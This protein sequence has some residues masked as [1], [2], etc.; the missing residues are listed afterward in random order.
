MKMTS[1]IQQVN[2]VSQGLLNNNTEQ[3]LSFEFNGKSMTGYA[4]DTLASAL[5]ANGEKL[6][7][8]SF[9]YHRPRGIFSAG[10]EEPNALVELRK[11]AYQEPNTRA[12]IIELFDGLEAKSQNYRGSLKYDLM[13]INDRL[14][15][16]LSA[17]FYYKTFMW[18]KAFWEKLYEPIIRSSAGLGRLSA[19]ED[20]D[21]YDKGFLHCDLLIIGAGPAGLAAALQ[22]S[23]SGAKVLVADEDFLLGGR[24]NAENHGVAG[25]AGHEWAAST[26]AEL[27]SLPNVRIMPRTS[28]Y[29]SFDHGIYGA[30]ERKTDHLASSGGKPRQVLWRI[31][32]KQALLCAGSTERPIAFANNDR[33][34]V[35][36]A[37]SVRT[38]V[39]RY[40]VT[41]GQKVAVFT[42]NDDGWRTAVD[43]SDKGVEISAI[44]D[45]RDKA[46]LA[47]PKGAA[48]MMGGSVIN[49]AGRHGIREITLSNG[50]KVPTDCLAVSGGWNPNVHLTCHQRGKPEWQDDISAFVP[51]HALPVGMQVAGAANGTLT[52][53]SALAEGHAKA[54]EMVSNIG[55]TP[56]NSL[57]PDSNDESCAVSAFWYV[58]SGKDRAWLDLQNDVTVK[59]IKLSHQEGFR[60]VEHLKRYTTLGMATD[61]GKTSNVNALAVMADCTGK[62]IPETGTTIFRPPYTPVAIGALAGRARGKDFRP[63]RLTP[64]HRW[65]EAQG[66]VFVET[67]MW[68]RAQ[69][70]PQAGETTWRESV[71]REVIQT[72]KSVGICDVTTLGK[73]DIQ[74]RDAAAFLNKIYANAFAKLPVGK[75]RYGLMLREDG[76][77][78]DD[79]TT[80]RFSDTHFVMTTTTAN[81]VS[82]F[83]HMEFARQCLWPD[84]DVQLLSATEQFAQ[85][86]VA[87]PNSRKLLQKIVD[88]DYAIDNES[89]PFM[90]CAEITVCNGIPARLFR[91]S[92][93]GELAYEIA[94]PA[95]YG[96]SLFRV[97]MEAGQEYDVVPYGT[98]ALGVMRI[99]KGHAAGNELNGQIT[100]QN[101]G[102]GR[103]VSKKKDCIG[104]KL[105]ER[106]ALNTDN[107][108][109]LVGFRPVDVTEMLSSGAHFIAIGAEASTE[110]DQGWMSS[111]CYSPE[112]KMSVGIGFIQNGSQRLGEK[113]RAVDLVRGKD[114]EV[115]ITSAHH[116]DPEGERLRG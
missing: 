81:A 33:P 86:A 25:A 42:N 63:T 65:A 110:N 108:V 45:T 40:G 109:E 94:V 21:S 18:P 32:S 30:L 5:L 41:A 103:L 112:L 6:V 75:V 37:G 19:I 7:A 48:V 55:Y 15:P 98:E 8:R 97:L 2:R 87:G 57:A 28:I 76:I 43:L 29:G 105:S 49:T 88:A 13:A 78:M 93:S 95:R 14:S 68:L 61:Q 46:P 12:T 23:R 92:F 84:L 66:A 20:G 58:D 83:R 22:A 89:F 100:A 1:Q 54:S 39:N 51:G 35:M 24:L 96:D 34:G 72:R 90:A 44:I 111:V 107:I 59:D 82:V 77:A 74:G 69:W 60:S 4:G 79:G 36:L 53:A 104:N 62:T 114:I 106:S 73:I 50:Q 115:E 116:V 85:Y 101:L 71:D 11:G 70:F 10:S 56:S 64:S 102:M 3:S 31:Y 26:V 99:E 16:F 38:Y 9:K 52:L 27:N 80:A 67:G 113:V 91:I 17:G 47:A